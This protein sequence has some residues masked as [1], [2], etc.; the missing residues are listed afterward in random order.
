MKNAL[1]IIARAPRAE[2]AKTR[3]GREI[4]HGRAIA[5]YEA[6]LTDLGARFSDSPFPLGWYVTPPD[7]WPDI[8]PLVGE[9]ERVLFQG[10]GDLTRRQ[11]DLF[12]GAAKRGEGKVVLMAADSP[13]LEVETVEEA[14]RLLD[15]RDI[16][17]GPTYDGGYYLVAMSRPHDVFE[18][19]MSTGAELDDVIKRIERSG[20]SVGLLE[21]TF[22]IDVAEDIQ[23]LIRPALERSDLAATRAALEALGLMEE[24]FAGEV[25]PGGEKG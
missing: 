6:F 8:S 15:E 3:L 23:H 10:E 11:R 1:Y 17:L 12:L 16:V 18:G 19:P 13:Q 9:N 24:E 21:A 4:G 2:F 5:L 7:G 20:L 25:F 14:F 22:D